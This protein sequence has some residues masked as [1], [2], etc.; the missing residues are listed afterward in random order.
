MIP[1]YFIQKSSVDSFYLYFSTKSDYVCSQGHNKYHQLAND[2][3]S[4]HD[5][6]VLSPAKTDVWYSL[7]ACLLQQCTSLQSVVQTSNPLH[8][9]V[10][11]IQ[12]L[13][14]FRA[15][16]NS[17]TF[18]P[19]RLRHQH[20]RL[21]CLQLHL[22]TTTKRWLQTSYIKSCSHEGS[23][24]FF[25]G[26]PSP[27]WTW[28]MF[29]RTVPNLVRTSINGDSNVTWV[30]NLGQ[31]S[32]I[33]PLWKLPDVRV[34]C[35]SAIFNY[36]LR[37]WSTSDILMTGGPLGELEDRLWLKIYLKKLKRWQLQCTVTWCYPTSCQSFSPS[38]M[39][40][41]PSTKSVNQSVP[42]S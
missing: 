16:H 22:Q 19:W 24:E 4:K 6:L 23:K 40:P 13:N 10:Q 28:E 30:Q 20:A 36:N 29:G 39:M 32:D 1:V 5:A 35:P 2:N 8:C 25:N 17:I 3:F 42:D 31:I 38:N 37:Q 21:H 26:P 41:I 9:V 14:I 34:K 18:I 15:Y 27:R 11:L 7:S 33:L 12:M